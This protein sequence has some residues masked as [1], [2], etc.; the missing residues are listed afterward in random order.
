MKPESE[1]ILDN[2]VKTVE[3]N[4]VIDC[5][6]EKCEFMKQEAEDMFKDIKSDTVKA[7]MM[8][9]KYLGA[10]EL[11]DDIEAYKEAIIK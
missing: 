5:L 1:K 7:R 6:I 9:M 3:Y 11:I 4:A 8:Y 10:K 2:F